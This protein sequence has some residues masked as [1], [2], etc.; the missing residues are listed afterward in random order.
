[1]WIKGILVG[2]IFF[3]VY[4]LFSSLYYL[5]GSVRSNDLKIIKHLTYR[6]AFS[7]L[8]FI[9]ILIGYSVDLLQPNLLRF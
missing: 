9:I 4:N 1:M 2:L 5:L 6:V 3:V 7:L 8:A